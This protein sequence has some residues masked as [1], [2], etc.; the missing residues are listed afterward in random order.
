M[1]TGGA[2]YLGSILVPELLKAGHRVSVIDNF[3]YSQNS[4]LD[5]CFLDDFMIVRGDARDGFLGI[6]LSWIAGRHEYLK[7]LRYLNRK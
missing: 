6:T 5:C 2:G 1:V 4:L 7:Y 3:M